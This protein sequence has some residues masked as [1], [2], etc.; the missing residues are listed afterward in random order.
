MPN[1]PI[2]EI[3]EKE[4][5]PRSLQGQP[6]K[7]FPFQKRI[8]NEFF[9]MEGRGK[10]RRLKYTT[11]VYSCPKKSGKTEI[12]G[13]VTYA[14]ARVFGGEMYSVANDAE[15]AG[16]RMFQRVV[17]SLKALR[18]QDPKTFEQIMPDDKRIRDKITVNNEV[19]FENNSQLNAGPHTLKFIAND[20]AG[21]A[22]AM[23][24]FVG[25]DELWGVSSERGER[26]WTEMQPIPNLTASIMVCYN[27]RRVLWR[28]RVVVADL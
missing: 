10:A 21:E 15:Q 11:M 9:K 14:F 23:N 8:L 17:E 2:I 24:A 27:V 13:A 22:G 5:R 1:S 7:L 18:E 26:L 3:I 19:L 6:L 12:M 16:A 25:F 20:F 28:E 4:Y